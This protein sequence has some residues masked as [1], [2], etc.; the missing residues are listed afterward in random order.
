MHNTQKLNPELARKGLHLLIAFVPALAAINLSGTAIL[1][2][3]GM[4]VYY[5]AEGLRFLGFSPPLISSITKFVLRRRED[6]RFALGPVTLGLGALLSLLLFPPKTAALAIYVLAFADCA[7]GLV[8][9]F[10][11]R[12]RPAFMAGKS[13]EGTLAGFVA[14]A[15]AGFILFQDAKI[16]LAAGII[17]VLVDLLPLGDFDNLILP[18]A[19]GLTAVSF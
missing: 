17:S 9:Q 11:G 7:A 15:A 12:H 10:L 18:L 16:A 2:M 19:V 13:V 5:W 8:G 14:A 6:G 1:L 3:S 4:L